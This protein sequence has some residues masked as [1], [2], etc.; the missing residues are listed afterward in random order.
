MRYVTKFT[1][2][3]EIDHHFQAPGRDIHMHLLQ[4]TRPSPQSYNISEQQSKRYSNPQSA[5]APSP[6]QDRA[7]ARNATSRAHLSRI[8]VAYF[9]SEGMFR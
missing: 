9:T 6:L 2:Y 3:L 1:T 5:P 8:C 4:S 7:Q